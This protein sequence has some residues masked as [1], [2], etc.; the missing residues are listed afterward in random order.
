MQLEK[1]QRDLAVYKDIHTTFIIEGNVHDKQPWIFPEDDYCEPISLKMY[2]QRFLQKEGYDIIIFYNPIDGFNNPFNKIMVDRFV[3]ITGINSLE[4]VSVCDA[5]SY[6]RTALEGTIDTVAIIYEMANT[7]AVV[8]DNLSD[9]EEKNFAKLMLMSKNSVQAISSSKQ[10]PLTNVQFF[11]TDKIND[12]PA[13]FYV[14]NPY[15]KTLNVSK[16][17]KEVRSSIIK[18]RVNS[19]KGTK[20]L[21]EDEKKKIV[22]EFTLLTDGMSL[23]EIDGIVALCRYQ[24]LTVEHIKEAIFMFKYG[25]NESHWDKIDMDIVNNIDDILSKRVK[26]QTYAISKVSSILKRSCLGLTELQGGA[27]SRPKGVLF[28]AG[29]TGTGKTELAKSIA[30]MIFGDESFLTRFDMSEYG[31]PHS[32]QKLLGAPPGYVGYSAGGQ[33][34]N[35][36]KEK[37]FSVLLF[38]EIEKAHPSIL[39]KFLQI[40]EDG[41][42]TDSSGETVYFSETLI[43]FTSNLGITKRSTSGASINVVSKEMDYEQIK[44]G[45][46]QEIKEYF[47]YD[48]NR[49]ELLNRIGDNF[50]VFDYIR[51]DIAKRILSYKVEKIVDNLLKSKQIKLNI[52]DAF[53]NY[54]VEET[55]NNLENGGRGIGNVIES[56]LVNSIASIMTEGNISDNASITLSSRPMKEKDLPEYT[57][58]KF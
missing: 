45:V 20:E 57:I 19:I 33:L 21:N 50:I 4:N 22:D 55:L 28:F 12:I 24:G 2:L 36:I 8:P 13:W 54:L 34:T 10:K 38:D 48:I 27:N 43:I 44:E 18:S 23:V 40:L 6:A 5:I 58:Y 17:E 15:V 14:N 11:V 53:Y 31:Q 32:D 26:G 7:L 56:K 30:E 9:S 49:P 16:P 39:D 25:T 3:K 1:W 47:K 35:A 46:L 51:E 42:L 41:R 37:P 52:E 29:P